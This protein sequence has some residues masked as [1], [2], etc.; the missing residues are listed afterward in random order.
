[1]DF[2]TS[3]LR[4]YEHAE[5]IGLVDN[6]EQSG[7]ILLPIYH[8]NRRSNG[9]DTIVV[10]LDKTGQFMKAEY[11]ADGET[12][13]FPVTA[14]SVARS[15]KNPAPHPLVDKLTYFVSAHN[16]EQYETYHQQLE[17]WINAC[18]DKQVMSYLSLI[19]QF[20][21][22]EDFLD[23]ICQSLF[24]KRLS[25]NGL[26]VTYALSEEKEKT[27]DLSA[28]FLT[29]QIA[30]FIGFKT[31]SVTNFTALHK[32]YIAYLMSKQTANTICNIS[33]QK[34]VLATKHRGLLGNA[35]L[36]SVSNHAEAYK[37]RFRERDDV[38][39]VGN[40]TSEKLHL[41]AK[42]FLEH[43]QTHAW[44]G[45]GQH[46]I[47][48]FSDDLAND[49]QLNITQA[50]L[51]DP[52]DDEETF[53]STPMISEENKSINRSFITGQRQFSDSASY[54]VAILNKTNDGRIALKYFRQLQASSL[55]KNLAV[56]Q[57]NYSWELQRKG[58]QFV[59][60]LP[61]FKEI[62]LAAYGVDRDRSLELDND[63]FRSDQYQRL[64]TSLIAGKPLP[65]TIVKKLEANIKQRQ[66]YR[67]HW[68]Q[69]EHIS[70]AILHKQN[71]EEFTPML[72]RDNTNRSY[73]FGRLLGIYE[74]IEKSRNNS[75]GRAK[76]EL[77]R[78]TN[79]ERYWTAYAN[80][81]ASL[82]R[83][84]EDK[85]YPY[86]EYLKINEAGLWSKLEKEREEIIAL[87]TSSLETT[88]FNK[89]LDYRFIFGYYAEKKYFYTPK[90]ES[91][92]A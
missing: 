46:M 35:K 10:Q 74:L 69:V 20:I 48:W 55:L 50:L 76:D 23:L 52:F 83:N 71:G 39:R 45:S 41:M 51:L 77:K 17:G 70:L 38:F 30:Q 9:K 19:Q 53:L 29:F 75:K 11:L 8:T 7:T 24:G 58:N 84:L 6:Q 1:M 25:R 56:W 73:L 47:N 3:L 21:L 40:Q 26:K 91:E 49:S 34:E 54:Y 22:K 72:D 65:D 60:K 5:D 61:S 62:I 81:P 92:D 79:A 18:Q 63:N 67:K 66:K 2:F 86:S 78:I 64:V 4:A 57:E 88:D 90:D 27:V 14:E 80:R 68:H 28:C 32:D 89:P 44:L 42:Y 12:I 85:I 59:Q 16:Q 33:G 43:E 15:G 82:M 13:I 37:G 36:I 31:V 87:L